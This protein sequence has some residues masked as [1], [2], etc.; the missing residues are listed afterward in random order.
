[1]AVFLC[2]L[3]VVA[4]IAVMIACCLSVVYAL[5]LF[6]P[7]WGLLKRQ[8]RDTPLWCRCWYWG[9]LLLLL[10]ILGAIT[11]PGGSIPC[12]LMGWGIYGIVRLQI[13]A[14]PVFWLL[15]YWNWQ[16]ELKIPEAASF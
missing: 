6:S 7:W 10:S 1:M 4:L 16:A 13:A 5:C 9:W 3:G 11:D 14:I 2:I 8:R 15:A 12:N